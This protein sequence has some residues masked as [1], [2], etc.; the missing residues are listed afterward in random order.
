MFSGNNV[1]QQY[2]Y[3]SP[4]R[5]SVLLENFLPGFH[6]AGF[7]ALASMPVVM[8]IIGYAFFWIKKHGYRL[9]GPRIGKLLKF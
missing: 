9:A 2:H 6:T 5:F 7:I 1:Q 3:K 8:V 4:S